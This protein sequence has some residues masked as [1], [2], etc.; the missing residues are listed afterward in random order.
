[1]KVLGRVCDGS[2]IYECKVE[3]NENIK[4]G[5][6]VIM[7][8]MDGEYVLGSIR[9]A[10]AHKDKTIYK[11]HILGELH[12][13]ILLPNRSPIDPNG[14]VYYCDD[15]IL[16]QIFA[17]EKGLDIGHVLTR[18]NI[19]VKLDVN[20]LVSRHFAILAITGGGKSNTVAVLC[21]ELAK[22]N[23]TVVM[24]DPHGEYSTM[25]HKVLDD[26]LNVIKATLDPS[27]LSPLEFSELLGIKENERRENI[28]LTM[29][30][31]TVKQNLIEIRK[32]LRGMDF[33]E[34]LEKLV[35]EWINKSIMGWEIRFYDNIY[36]KYA[37]RKLE[38]EDTDTLLSLLDYIRDFE[39]SFSGNIEKGDILEKIQ[40]NK[41]NIID[42]GGFEA[43]QMNALVTY[44]GKQ[45]L[46]LRISYMKSKKDLINHPDD[47]VRAQARKTIQEIES[48]FPGLIK[49]ILMIVEE[50]HIFIP[51]DRKTGAT[52]WLGKISREGRKFGVGLGIVSQQP[53]KLNEDILSQANTKIILKI[54][55]PEDQK[56]IQKSSENLGEELIKNLPSLGIG[57]AIIS[58]ISIKLPVIVKIDRFDGSYGGEDIDIYGEWNAVYRY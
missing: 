37:T 56:Y 22:I 10:T 32:E 39:A 11:V 29:A 24:M 5:E 7:E 57:E 36:K 50:A 6:F 35:G 42:L 49:P 45:I 16:S 33:V 19:R 1:V 28:F 38:K 20:K 13:N 4:Y 3:S 8:N 34:E 14:E 23:S 53:K 2:S 40:P 31:D 9:D 44:V 18:D 52:Y 17:T 12:D 26:K 54:V 41:I 25:K 43:N 55:E 30:Y 15:G 27:I 48:K 21:K 51:R 58:G 46:R 47:K